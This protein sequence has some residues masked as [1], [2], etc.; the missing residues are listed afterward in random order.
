MEEMAIRALSPAFI[1]FAARTKLKQL[2]KHAIIVVGG[3]W[4]SKPDRKGNKKQNGNFNFTAAG[5]VTHEQVVQFQHVFLEHLK[6]SAVVTVGNWVWAQLCNVR[7]TD[8][9]QNIAGPDALMK[10]MRHNPILTSVPLPQ[11]PHYACAPH[12]LVEYTTVVFAYMDST[13]NVAK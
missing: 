4:V 11:M 8:H 12:N 13:G 9:Q 2:A 1:I 6:I 7:T 10:E 3:W 5:N